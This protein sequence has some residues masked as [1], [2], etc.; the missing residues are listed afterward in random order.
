MVGSTRRENRNRLRL[1]RRTDIV[2][3]SK[4]SRC[5]HLPLTVPF[6]CTQST[7]P[8]RM[9][10]ALMARGVVASALAWLMLQLGS[11]QLLVAACH[12]SYGSE[13]DQ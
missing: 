8:V 9:S 11:R 6:G 4:D 12:Q 1:G 7:P 5:P 10:L 3:I 13:A 2:V